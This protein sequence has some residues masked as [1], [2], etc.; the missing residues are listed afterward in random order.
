MRL[1]IPLTAVLTALIACGKGETAVGAE[2]AEPAPEG[3]QEAFTDAQR[4]GVVQFRET[5]HETLRSCDETWSRVAAAGQS[6]DPVALY[7]VAEDVDAV[8]GRVALIVGGLE[9]P[10]TLPDSLQTQLAEARDALRDAT[11]SRTTAAQAIVRGLDDEGSIGALADLER[12]GEGYQRLMLE[13]TLGLE[14]VAF[15][16]GIRADSVAQGG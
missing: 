5:V 14:A 15:A 11:L 13:G 10:D 7:R 1:L 4:A 3:P 16:V 8:C 2:T 9:E 12:A 6:E